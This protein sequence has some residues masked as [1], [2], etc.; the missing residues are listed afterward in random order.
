MLTIEFEYDSGAVAC[1]ECHEYQIDGALCKLTLT[2]GK[3]SEEYYLAPGD[4]IVVRNAAG[5]VIRVIRSPRVGYSTACAGTC[6]TQTVDTTPQQ[7]ASLA[8]HAGV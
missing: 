5:S 7:V 6:N 3:M 1:R 4:T 8:E 2:K